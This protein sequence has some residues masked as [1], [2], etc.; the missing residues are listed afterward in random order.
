ME[1]ELEELVPH[2]KVIQFI[3]S[4]KFIEIDCIEEGSIIIDAPDIFLEYCKEYTGL[5]V[6]DFI[7]HISCS[8]KYYVPDFETIL[9]DEVL[10]E[11]LGRVAKLDEKNGE[12]LK[13]MTEKLVAWNKKDTKISTR[14]EEILQVQ[15][16]EY[17]SKRAA[18]NP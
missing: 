5:E 18:E 10:A 17:E 12:M 2:I 7:E 3:E 4:I 8:K 9:N 14:L 11:I 13:T 15:V 16:D 6:Q 1:K